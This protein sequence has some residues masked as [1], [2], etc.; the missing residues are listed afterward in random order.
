MTEWSK[1]LIFKISIVV[2]LFILWSYFFIRNVKETGFDRNTQTDL[3]VCFALAV[4]GFG[5][6][7]LDMHGYKNVTR[8]LFI[9]P[10]LWILL[11]LNMVFNGV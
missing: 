10:I 11:L 4:F 9:I 7:Y 6:Y 5:I 3:I 2:L 1:E 8:V